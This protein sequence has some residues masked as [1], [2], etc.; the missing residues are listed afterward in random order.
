MSI[1][2][3]IFGI[4]EFLWGKTNIVSHY[5]NKILSCIQ[6]NNQEFRK[7][8]YSF[9]SNS[10]S[11]HTYFYLNRIHHYIPNICTSNPKMQDNYDKFCNQKLNLSLDKLISLV[12]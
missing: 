7:I 8:S 11:S 9:R 6:Y 10:L 4:E 5:L 12:L 3:C 1:Y 2:L